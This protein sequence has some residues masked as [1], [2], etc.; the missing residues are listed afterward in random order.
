MIGILLL[1]WVIGLYNGLVRARN[2]FRNAFAQIDVQ[3]KRR[4]D[5][6]PNLVEVAK[7][8][9]KHE[10][11]TLE[12]VIAMRNSAYAAEQKAVANPSDPNAMKELGQAESQ[13]NGALGRLLMVAEQYPDLKNYTERVQ[14]VV[15]VYGREK[16]AT[17]D[18]GDAALAVTAS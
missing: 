12:A 5:L 8:Y 14:A 18:R 4:H 15:G 7:G 17:L 2:R 3:L 16:H 13:L 9:M 1:L 11:E 6:I 10:K